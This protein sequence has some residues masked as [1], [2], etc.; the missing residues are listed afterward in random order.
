MLL[1]R[2]TLLLLTIALAI[3]MT[4]RSPAPRGPFV[5]RLLWLS[6]LAWSVELAGMLMARAYIPN[7]GLYNLFVGLE[8][9]VMLSLVDVLFPA[10]RRTLIALG[11]LGLAVLLVTIAAKGLSAYMAIEGIIVIGL[12]CS[13]VIVRALIG[14]AQRSEHGLQR[15]PAF[16]VL[17]GAFLYFSGT[18]PILSAWRFMGRVSTELS[19]VLYWIVVGL[20][21]MRYLLL[22]WAMHIERQQRLAQGA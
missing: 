6:V 2:G 21:M 8:F 16:W 17:T 4:W 12:I 1:I 18:I 13:A 15:V 7:N 19:T 11:A 3:V 14:L 9:V 10:W 22:A 5:Q 20:A